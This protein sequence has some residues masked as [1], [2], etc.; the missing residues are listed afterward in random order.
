MRAWLAGSI[1][2]LAV[3][4]HAG[5]EP[6]L[7]AVRAGD[8]A[9]ALALLDDGADANAAD[10]DGTT[11][12]VWAAH[13]GD[14]ELVARLIEAGADVA[15]ANEYGASAMAEAAAAGDAAV[16]EAL[17]EGGADPDSPNAD[18]QTALMAVARTGR[19]DA[20]RLLLDAGAAV[21]AVEFWGGQTAL[22]WAASQSQPEMIRLLIAR[23]ADPDA[24]GAVRDWGRRMTAES[25]VKDM[26]TGGFTPLLYA[27]REG[28]TACARA[29][30]EGGADIDLISPDSVTPLLMAAINV[31]FDTAAYLV[32]AGADVNR[33]DFWG[34]NALYAVVDV[35]TTPRGG[36]PDLP[37][38]DETTGLALM[39]K[40]LAAGARIDAQLRLFPPYRHVGSD[41]GGDPI[42]TVGATPLLRAA[43]GGDIEAVELLLR[44]DPTV[45]LP[46]MD[47]VTPLMAAAGHGYRGADTRGRFMNEQQGLQ[48]VQLLLAAGAD[49]NARDNQ[50]RG[51]VYGATNR[52]WHDMIR[53]LAEN[54]ADLHAQDENDLTALDVA[55]GRRAEDAVGPAPD[56]K[57]A[58]AALLRELMG[59]P[60]ASED[61]AGVVSINEGE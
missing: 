9:A 55:E 29:L 44:H 15:H 7:D 8:R 20:A 40:L 1:L 42:L 32:E 25:R 51:A 4:G 6:L 5:A 13:Q 36:R 38:D 59:L 17:L 26:T 45:D 58:T 35:N 24:R 27:A 41:R 19:I 2:A 53:L 3:A 14:A 18:G 33:W 60:P 37:A 22:M 50:G 48:E 56:P 49:I 46:N 34:R 31:H 61:G 23:G 21:D 12:L 57:P 52:A 10:S 43:K 16:I 54:G 30:V 47:G 28:C 11:A 39:E